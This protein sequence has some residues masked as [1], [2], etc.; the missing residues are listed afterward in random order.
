MGIFFT[1]DSHFFHKR[2]LDFRP[3]DSIEEMNE[4][5]I[6]NWNKVVTQK[7]E[8]WHLGDVSF[9]NQRDS[10]AL[11]RRLNGRKHLVLGNHD[12]KKNYVSTSFESIQNY[13]EMKFDKQFLVLCHF[14][15][16]KW[17]KG[18]YG[19]IH[20]HGHSH[21]SL[22][23][24]PIRRFD[25]GVDTEWANYAPISIDRILEEAERYPVAAYHH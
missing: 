2:M 8:V 7:D 6:D 9:G 13:K 22:P 16:L 25:V 24:E 5:I 19:S 10:Q 4:A 3:F 12:R 17:N 15:I 18:H 21:G 11:V 23:Q 14:P 20:L 1:A